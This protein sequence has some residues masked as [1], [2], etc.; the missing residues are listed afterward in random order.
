MIPWLLLLAY[1]A[2]LFVCLPRIFAKAGAPSWAGWV[3]GYN[4]FVWNRILGKPWYW[5]ILLLVP[6][7]NLLMLIIYNVNTSIAFNERTLKQH[8][9][10]ALT[11]WTTL[12]RLAFK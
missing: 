3:P 8:V 1:F 6:G 4:L 2:V 12:P 11:P 9:I 10:A 5:I 7:I